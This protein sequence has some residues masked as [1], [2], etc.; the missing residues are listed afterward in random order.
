MLCLQVTG[1]VQLVEHPIL[2]GEACASSV[3]SPSKPANLLSVA[4]FLQLQTVGSEAP[5]MRHT[6][7]EQVLACE[8]PR[9]HCRTCSQSRVT[10]MPVCC[11]Y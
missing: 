8:L 7:L 1:T 3:G 6:Y 9:L 11:P 2:P 4:K 5:H 10:F